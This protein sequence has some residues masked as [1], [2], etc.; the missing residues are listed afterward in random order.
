MYPSGKQPIEI[1]WKVDILSIMFKV[2][3][4]LLPVEPGGNSLRLLIGARSDT[5]C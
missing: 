1:G 2:R 5:K 4:F 3:F